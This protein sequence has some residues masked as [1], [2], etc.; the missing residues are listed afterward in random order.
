MTCRD[1][2][3][4]V[5]DALHMETGRCDFSAAEIL[6]RMRASGSVYRDSTIKTHVSAHMVED[7]TLLRVSPGRFRLARHRDRPLE[8]HVQPPASETD[9]RITEDQVKAAVKAHLEAEGWAVLVAW[10]RE[11]GI[12]IEAHR[13]DEGLV[14]EAKGEAPAGPQQVNYFLG[15]LGELIQRMDDPNARYGVALPD[16][17][18][19]RGLVDRLPGL[20]WE[21][22]KLAVYFVGLE[23]DGRP[24]VT[25]TLV[26]R[27]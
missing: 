23:R 2:V 1:D 18:Q 6:H 17:R 3:S 7:G 22:L 12:D 21:R 19:Y 15:A 14:I 26:N 8:Q 25:A 5:F 20:A 16:H 9:V 24:V 4:A 10:G 11:R 13:A 27:A